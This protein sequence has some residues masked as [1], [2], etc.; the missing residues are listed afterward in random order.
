MEVMKKKIP[1]LDKVKGEGIVWGR[2][3]GKFWRRGDMVREEQLA[4]LQ[5]GQLVEEE[6]H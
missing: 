1:R 2:R 3:N 6:S 4:W 5:A